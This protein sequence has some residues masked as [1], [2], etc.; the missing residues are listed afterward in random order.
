[1]V[2]VAFAAVV[3]AD[4]DGLDVSGAVGTV[5]VQDPALDE[6]PV[7]D[8]A[9]VGIAHQGVDAAEE[10][11]QSSSAKLPSKAVSSSSRIRPRSE[12]VSSEVWAMRSAGDR[13]MNSDCQA[14]APPD[15][16]Y[17]R[18]AQARPDRGARG[19]GGRGRAVPGGRANGGGGDGRAGGGGCGGGDGGSVHRHAVRGERLGDR[20]V[21]GRARGARAAGA[22]GV[23]AEGDGSGEVGAAA[24][25]M[26]PSR[27]WCGPC[28]R[29]ARR[30]S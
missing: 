1:M 25:A 14:P 28:C 18:R 10:C 20:L 2:A 29:R 16:E 5:R 30:R 15:S 6:A 3:G 11:S 13:S 27:R 8:R 24:V 22:A 19:P 12:A 26:R 21:D 7:G 23:D 9:A 17:R 4:G